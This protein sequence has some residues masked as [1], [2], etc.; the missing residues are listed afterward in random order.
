MKTPLLPSATPPAPP[1]IRRVFCTATARRSC[2]S[3]CAQ[4]ANAVGASVRDSILLV[5]PMFHANAWGLPFAAAGVG[6]K[7]VL[8]GMK[9]DGEN[10]L[11]LMLDEGATFAAGIPTVWLNFVAWLEQNPGRL[12]RAKLRLT[13]IMSGGSAPPPALIENLHRLLGATMVQA[14]GMTETSPIATAGTLLAE[15]EGLDLAGR[16]DIQRRQGRAIFGC[17]LRIVDD[18]GTEL[19]RDGTSVGEI[20]VTRSLGDR[21]IFQRRRRA[22]AGR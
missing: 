16:T 10:L 11:A 5:V 15:H 2:A 20:Q 13:R 8:P 1:A 22:G 14:W 6:A 17:E 9:M 18:A 3:F 19:P 7:L 21:R 12:D 4:A